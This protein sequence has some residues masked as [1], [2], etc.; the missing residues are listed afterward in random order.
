MSSSQELLSTLEQITDLPVLVIG[1]LILD[2]Y[3]WG[4][5]DR[6]SPEAPVPIVHVRRTEDRLGGAGNAV[7]NLRSL[8]ARVELCGILGDDDEGRRLLN[9]FLESGIGHDSVFVDSSQPTSLKTRVIA[10]S[11]QVVRI[12]REDLAPWPL[13]STQLFLDTV[14]ERALKA[15]VIVISDYGKGTITEPCLKLLAQLRE[16]G[17]LQAPVVVDPHPANYNSY[18]NITVAKPNRLEAEKASGIEIV[19]QASAVQAA[20]VLLER[21][22]ADMMLITLG[23]DGLV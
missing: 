23:E 14:R 7:R 4:K 13:A 2:Q 8:G 17:E 16:S 19:D 21:W 10:H 3:I 20:Q 15:K 11:Q 22:K 18:S 5:V 6:I 9:L 1:D 12:D